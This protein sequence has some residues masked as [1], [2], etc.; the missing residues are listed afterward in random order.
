MSAASHSSVEPMFDEEELK[1]PEQAE[2]AFNVIAKVSKEN[3]L[4]K[5]WAEVG[6]DALK[7]IG[8]WKKCRDAGDES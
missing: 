6:P 8:Y 2:C 7:H 3:G 5:K 1:L 4:E